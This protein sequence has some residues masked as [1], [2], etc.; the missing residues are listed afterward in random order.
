MKTSK[1]ALYW[2]HSRNSPSFLPSAT[3]T[4]SYC[5][6]ERNAISPSSFFNVNYLLSYLRAS[7]VPPLAE[8]L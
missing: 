1:A 6:N 4:F 8:M 3:K 7:S 2:A 5:R